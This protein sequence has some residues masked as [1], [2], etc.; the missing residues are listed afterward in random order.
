MV[1]HVLPVWGARN[2]VAENHFW[3]SS[4]KPNWKQEMIFHYRLVKTLDS[5]LVS[6]S[7]KDWKLAVL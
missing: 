1:M 7:Q 5:L 4:Q 6:E 2:S 3:A